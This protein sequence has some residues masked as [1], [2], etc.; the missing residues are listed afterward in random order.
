[1]KVLIAED[2]ALFRKALW[3][4]LSTEF[5]IT[6]VQD[7][8][9]AATLLQQE[10][11]PALALLDWV[12]P[13]LTGPQVCRELRANPAS[14]GIYIILL[15][16]RNSAADIVAGLRAGADDYVTKPFQ[17][18]ELLARVRLGRR[19]LEMQETMDAKSA[20]L[21]ETLAREHLLQ[22]RLNSLPGH[23]R[24]PDTIPAQTT[25]ALK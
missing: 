3:H 20:T 9:A 16:A 4:L 15:T 23:N 13:G 11:H 21:A 17:A 7:G 19:I 14:A 10:G 1:V 24:W 5:E 22:T 2:D 18:E 25:S 12:M 8:H 6:A